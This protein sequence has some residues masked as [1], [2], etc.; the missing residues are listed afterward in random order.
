M[1][2][3][4]FGGKEQLYLAVL[5]GAYLGIRKAE[6]SLQVGDLDPVEAVRRWPS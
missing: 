2:Y 6:Q 1:I 5:E 3:Y 4:Y